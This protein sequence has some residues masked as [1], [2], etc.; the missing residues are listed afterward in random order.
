LTDQLLDLAREDAG[1]SQ[2]PGAPLDLAALVRGVVEDMR[3]LAEA[4]GLSL[5]VEDTTAAPLHGDALRL[6]QVLLN[7][8]DNAVKYTPPGGEIAVR[9]ERRNRQA[10]VTI[11]DTGVGIPAD[12]LP[13]VFDR[14]YRADKARSRE[15]GG[16]GLG[17]SIAQSIVAAHG[18][19]IELASAPGQGTT[20]TVTLPEQGPA[21]GD[22]QTASM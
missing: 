21:G 19:R 9:V 1:A 4:R 22:Q 20:C 13:H 11:R 8:V 7:L 16:T 6:R 2:R 18:G 3:P 14:F 15:Q 12:H 17:L 10:I 5:R